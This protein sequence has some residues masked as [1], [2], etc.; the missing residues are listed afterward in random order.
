MGIRLNGISTPFGGV[1]WEYTDEGQQYDFE[2]SILR[3][4]KLSVFIS[5]MCG[6]NGKYD[7]VRNTLK[8]KIEETQLAEVYLFE[9]EPASTLPAEK[10]YIWSLEDSDVGIFL[11]DNA[12]GVSQGVQK[13]INAARKNNIKSLFYFCDETSK[14][15]LPKV[16]QYINSMI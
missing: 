12:D 4:R 6:D 10:H 14:E 11:I 3:S 15:L 5:S 8:K 2:K 13:E 16:K 7:K 9:D 1:Q